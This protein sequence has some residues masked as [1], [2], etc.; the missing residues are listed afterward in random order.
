M[1]SLATLAFASIALRQ[2][3]TQLPP[4][5]QMDFSTAQQIFDSAARDA[6]RA[7]TPDKALDRTFKRGIGE[8]RSG[9]LAHETVSWIW[10]MSPEASA[11]AQG[12]DSRKKY[13]SD[14]EKQKAL[15]GM[16]SE[17]EEGRR[18]LVFM[19]TLNIFPSF[20]A[21]YGRIDRN[22][23]VE[24]LK[25]VRVV[26]QVGSRILQPESQPGDLSYSSG[27]DVATSAIPSSSS[28]TT[29]ENGR[30]TMS[31]NTGYYATAT[32]SGSSTTTNYY[33]TIV[34]Q[35]YSYYSGEF[36]VT[37][38]LF[39]KDGK[40]LIGPSDQEVTAIVIYGTNERHANFKLDD[41]MRFRKDHGA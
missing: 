8:I 30:A 36:E 40:P 31:D 1:F 5:L 35:K 33:T 25:G 3:Q 7:R 26:L 34:T 20:G 24:D 2:D 41:I 12:F 4:A 10:M 37:F 32:G 14:D 18:H 23:N 15:D 27:S 17:T 19:G 38:D 29:T 21:A 39:D 22:A 11:Y 9:P 13:W 6:E 16:K 28:S